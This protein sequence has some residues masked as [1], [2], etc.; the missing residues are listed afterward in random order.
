MCLNCPM[1]LFEP[2]RRDVIINCHMPLDVTKNK[3]KNLCAKKLCYFISYYKK[4][5]LNPFLIEQGIF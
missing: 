5:L 2:D 1:L 3:N 4:V